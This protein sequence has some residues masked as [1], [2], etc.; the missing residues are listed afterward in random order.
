[1]SFQGEVN[2]CVA[3]HRRHHVCTDRPGDPHSLYLYGTGLARQ[4]RGVRHARAGW[5]LGNNPTS[6]L[7]YMAT[8]ADDPLPQPRPRC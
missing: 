8:M 3:V 6:R 2:G 5:L 1:M 7:D 4:L